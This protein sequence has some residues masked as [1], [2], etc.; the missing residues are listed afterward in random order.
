[1][2]TV[3]GVGARIVV[4]LKGWDSMSTT[5]NNAHGA[6]VVH[7]TSQIIKSCPLLTEIKLVLCNICDVSAATLA[8]ALRDGDTIIDLDICCN[9]ISDHGFRPLFSHGVISRFRSFTGF[10]PE[11]DAGLHFLIDA[12]PRAT[13]LQRLELTVWEGISEDVEEKVQSKCQKL[14][15]HA[16]VD[17]M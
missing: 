11:T 17:T 3:V 10:R 2:G 13:N 9:G 12:L 14:G 1:M 7:C 4:N 8:T 5:P 15:I 16:T 6:A